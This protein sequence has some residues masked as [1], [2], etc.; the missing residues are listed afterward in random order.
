M[1]ELGL[2]PESFRMLAA[3]ATNDKQGD[4]EANQPAPACCAP[5]KLRLSAV[6]TIGG[7]VEA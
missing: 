5:G 3:R 4:G 1:S 6:M 2:T 7:D